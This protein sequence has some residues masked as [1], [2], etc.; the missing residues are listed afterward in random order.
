MKSN[1]GKEATRIIAEKY[2]LPIPVIETIIEAVYLDLRQTVED[3]SDNG[4]R[5]PNFGK[6]FKTEGN[7]KRIEIRKQIRINASIKR[8]LQNF[9]TEPE[10]SE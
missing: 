6:F 3:D 8:K 9:N 2:K 7:L 5:I 4:Y 1:V 10:S